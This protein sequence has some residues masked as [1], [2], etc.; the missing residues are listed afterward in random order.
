MS[1]TERLLQLLPG[2]AP[3]PVSQVLAA[4]EADVMAAEDGILSGSVSLRIEPGRNGVVAAEGLLTGPV[5]GTIGRLARSR[6][7]TLQQLA[8]A[9]EALDRHPGVDRIF[10]D[11]AVTGSTLTGLFEAASR[12]RSLSKPTITVAQ[13]ATS[14]GAV[15]AAATDKTFATP[16]A[17]TGSVSVLGVLTDSSDEA[18]AAGQT[19]HLV[20]PDSDLKG[21]GHPGSKI[22]DTHLAEAK[23]EATELKAI[24]VEFISEARKIDSVA[25]GKLGAKVFI[26]EAGKAAGLVDEI[27]PSLQHVLQTTLSEEKPMADPKKVAEAPPVAAGTAPEPTASAPPANQPSPVAAG[28][29][30]P[31]PIATPGGDSVAAQLAAF[32][33]RMGESLAAVTK[34][35]EAAEAAVAEL[36]ATSAS[37]AIGARLGALVTSGRLTAADRIRKEKTIGQLRPE[38][39]QDFLSDL[40]SSTASYSGFLEGDATIFSDGEADDVQI[41]LADYACGDQMPDTEDIRTMVRIEKESGGDPD[42]RLALL[43]KEAS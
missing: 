13:V 32:E 43:R 30:D 7:G 2:A 16:A 4:L 34:R 40:E 17:R 23:R 19:V 26:G 35:A 24:M 12:I 31:L 42:K 21:A 5:L 11:S 14:G 3:A 22:T 1:L 41:R 39:V 8:D 33:A 15:L 29:A 25:V 20:S 27:V 6:G 28:P 38:C 10:F 37:D 36:T 18:K 9:A